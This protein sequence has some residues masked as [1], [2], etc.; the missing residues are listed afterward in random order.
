MGKLKAKDRYQLEMA[1]LESLDELIEYQE[2][3]DSLA[4][5]YDMFFFCESLP[6]D[7]SVWYVEYPGGD[8][9]FRNFYEVVGFIRG[10]LKGSKD[11]DTFM[12]L[13]IES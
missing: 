12:S 8:M 2:K 6:G 4:K 1:G 11:I 3:A 10:Y 13:D 9:Q 5:D 7:D